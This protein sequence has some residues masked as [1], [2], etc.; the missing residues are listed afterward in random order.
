MNYDQLQIRDNTNAHRLELDINGEI[1]FIDYKKK[2]SK[3]LLTHTEVPA[4]LEGDGIGSALVEKTFRFAEEH[5]F[6]IVPVCS[7]VQAYLDKHVEWKK[8]VVEE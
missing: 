4:G 1:A 7:F 6:K 2:D 5:D 8:I 3:L